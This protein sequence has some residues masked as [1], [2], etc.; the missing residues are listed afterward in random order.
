MADVIRKYPSNFSKWYAQ[1][2]IDGALIEFAFDSD[3]TDAE[4]Q[5]AVD[6]YLASITPETT[7]ILETENGE[8]I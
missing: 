6:A 5:G 8:Q 4:I 3:P 7:V 1:V 2:L